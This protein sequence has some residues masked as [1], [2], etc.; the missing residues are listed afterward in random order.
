MRNELC[1]DFVL[2]MSNLK[3]VFNLLFFCPAFQNFNWTELTWHPGMSSLEEHSS[4]KT[5]YIY[6]Y[7]YPYILKEEGEGKLTGGLWTRQ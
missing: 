2:T 7:N 5:N 6:L 4:L 1:T 3:Q